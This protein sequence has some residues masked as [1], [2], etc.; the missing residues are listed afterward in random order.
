MPT[1]AVCQ[2]GRDTSFVL[3]AVG[4]LGVEAQLAA[5]L[6]LGKS[7]QHGLEIVLGAE[8]VAHGA[9][10]HALRARPPGDTALDL[11]SG[12]SPRPHDEARVFGSKTGFTDCSLD[13]T[14]T[15]HLHAACVDGTGLGMDGGT[16]VTL[17]EERGHALSR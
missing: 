5:R 15:V 6:S 10:R 1:H 9:Y 14:L 12:Q 4:E 11:L 3:R 13:P 16:G 17:D 2:G 7:T 8:A